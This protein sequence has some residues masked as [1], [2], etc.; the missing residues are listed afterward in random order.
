MIVWHLL[1]CGTSL[2]EFFPVCKILWILAIASFVIFWWLIVQTKIVTHLLNACVVN[3]LG[4]F[5]SVIVRPCPIKIRLIVGYYSSIERTSNMKS[6]LHYLA[7][8]TLT[9]Q[10]LAN[11]TERLLAGSKTY[12]TGHSVYAHANREQTSELLLTREGEEK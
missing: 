5:P 2:M 12:L 3:L 9:T 6:T 10:A 1:C 7:K 8:I 11:W 4:F